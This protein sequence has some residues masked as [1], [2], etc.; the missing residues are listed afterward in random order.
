MQEVTPSDIPNGFNLQYTCDNCSEIIN[1]D[2]LWFPFSLNP[3]NSLWDQVACPK[4]L[5]K[6]KIKFNTLDP[7]FTYCTFV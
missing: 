1:Q 3:D 2:Y 6:I 5:T 7:I 4:C